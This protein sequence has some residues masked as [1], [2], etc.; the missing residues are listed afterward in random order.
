MAN[1][2]AW[3]PVAAIGSE[4]SEIAPLD[5]SY[6]I[7]TGKRYASSNQ[8]VRRVASLVA[9]GLGPDRNGAGYVEMLKRLL[10]GGESYVRLYSYPINW[11]LDA[12]RDPELRA[13][14]QFIWTSGGSSMVWYGGGVETLWATGAVLTATAL[15]T[16]GAHPVIT[17]TGLPVSRL[18]ARPGEFLTVFAG[19]DDLVGSTAQVLAPAFSNASGVADIRLFS[20]PSNSTGRVNIGQPDT[21]VFKAVG[22]LPRAVQTVGGNWSYSWSFEEVF[23]DEVGGFVE[24]LTWY[25]P[26]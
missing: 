12:I 18:V 7:I 10:V 8:P 15:D 16:S 21:G 26:S 5:E 25:L 24:D 20:A 23:A 22:A 6:S 1:V 11:H 3:P 14:I 17:V 9:T 13:Q 4:W 2:Y 19:D